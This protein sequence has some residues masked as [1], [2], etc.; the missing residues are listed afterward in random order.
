MNKIGTAYLLWLGCLLQVHGLH[1]LYNGKILTGLLWMFSFGLFGFGQLIDLLLIPNMVDEHNIK[2]R[3]G[4]GLI[5][6]ASPHQAVIQRVIP[7]DTISVPTRLE[8][9][10]LLMKLLQAAEA[11]GGKLSVTQGVMA[12]GTSF[13]YVEATLLHMVREGYVEITNDP[14]TGVVTYEFKEL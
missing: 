14:E 1:R 4:Q 9:N 13:A 12:T 2:L 11:R 7:A 3:A 5:P 6:G 10:P 8:S